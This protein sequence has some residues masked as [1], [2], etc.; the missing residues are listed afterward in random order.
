M[1]FLWVFSCVWGQNCVKKK[2]AKPLWAPAVRLGSSSQLC[3]LCLGCGLRRGRGFWRPCTGVGER[4][5]WMG[6]AR[7]DSET[8]DKSPSLRC[9][10]GLKE[11][12]GGDRPG[13][14][15]SAVHVSDLSGADAINH[16]HDSNPLTQERK[17]EETLHSAARA[18]RK[19]RMKLPVRAYAHISHVFCLPPRPS[20]PFS[21]GVLKS[22]SHEWDTDINNPVC[23]GN[24]VRKW[25]ETALR[26]KGNCHVTFYR[27]QSW[28]EHLHICDCFGATV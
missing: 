3:Q 9:C 21:S 10:C 5:A 18:R 25:R 14:S 23:G 24:P 11:E 22:T 12:G 26:H 1:Y 4:W 7:E 15:P 28:Q 19:G 27:F 16:G 20:L 17:A 8:L 13:R 6:S 2:R